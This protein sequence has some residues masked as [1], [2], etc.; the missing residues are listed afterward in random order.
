MLKGILVAE[1][2]C[3]VV[4]IILVV[5]ILFKVLVILEGGVDLGLIIKFDVFRL[6]V[7]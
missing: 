7:I 5:R 1:V 3:V 2:F 4:F 6:M